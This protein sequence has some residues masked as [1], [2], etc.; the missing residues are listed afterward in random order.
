MRCALPLAAAALL[1][2]GCAAGGG[3]KPAAATHRP[4]HGSAVRAA[5][6]GAARTSA[7]LNERVEITGGSETFA[8]TVTGRFDF[9]RD[10][11]SLAV[12]FP[13][14]GI[15][16][17]E[18]TFADGKVYLLGAGGVDPGTWGTTARDKAEAH[19]VLRAPLNDPEHVLRQ[20]SAM[21]RVSRVGEESVHGVRA[22]HYRGMLDHKALTL[23]LAKD[24]R[25]KMD[26]ARDLVGDDLPAFADV[27]LDGRGRLVQT[28]MTLGLSEARVEVTTAFSNI[29]E[30][31]RVT[32]PHTEDTVPVSSVSGVL[33]G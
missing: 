5:L 13:Q 4:D 26:Q 29:G 10:R 1:C 23:R 24:V 7:R 28:R 12:D 33:T 32:V 19:Y 20:S 27:W 14:G 22:V 30:P 25:E 18:E 8:V 9:G 31:V 6:A 11:G 16:H 3:A 21:K 17:V 2:A 15:A